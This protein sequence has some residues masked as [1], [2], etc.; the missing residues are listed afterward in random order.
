MDHELSR[1]FF[2][3]M[4]WSLKADCLPMERGLAREYGSLATTL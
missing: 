2:V 1:T 4:E 3:V